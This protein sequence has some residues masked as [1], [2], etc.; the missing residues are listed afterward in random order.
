MKVKGSDCRW[1]LWIHVTKEYKHESHHLGEPSFMDLGSPTRIG[2]H[3]RGNH[4]SQL[5]SESVGSFLDLGL[6]SMVENG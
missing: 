3:L 6:I 2:S 5:Q 4:F 1:Y